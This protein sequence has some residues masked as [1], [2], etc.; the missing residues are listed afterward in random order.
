MP[1]LCISRS[2]RPLRSRSRNDENS[3][4]FR[5]ICTGLTGKLWNLENFED[6]ESAQRRLVHQIFEH[7]HEM[8]K[9][10][11]FHM[12]T[13][14]A[15]HLKWNVFWRRHSPL[16]CCLLAVWYA[17]TIRLIYCESDFCALISIN[18]APG[19]TQLYQS[20]SDKLVCGGGRLLSRTVSA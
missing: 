13:E 4:K 20:G 14:E 7:L 9:L 1:W 18:P 19:K 5:F 16:K 8:T 10:R 15:L 11:T 6:R 12:S 17:Q 3:N 2:L